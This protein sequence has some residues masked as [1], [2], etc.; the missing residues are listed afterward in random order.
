M[1]KNQLYGIAYFS[2]IINIEYLL[3]IIIYFLDTIRVDAPK[4]SF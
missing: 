3:L 2:Q 1:V 4:H